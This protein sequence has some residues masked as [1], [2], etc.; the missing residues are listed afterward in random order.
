[1]KPASP[2]DLGLSLALLPPYSEEQIDL[3]QVDVT[4]LRCTLPTL[5]LD[6]F[7]N[8][9]GQPPSNVEL[10]SPGVIEQY[11]R[12]RFWLSFYRPD[13]HGHWSRE[14]SAQLAE[15]ATRF[16][17]RQ[18]GAEQPRISNGPLILAAVIGGFPIKRC[19]PNSPN[20]LLRM[21]IAEP[22]DD[23]ETHDPAWPQTLQLSRDIPRG[24]V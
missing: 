5:R 8:P 23:L 15:S 20:V 2:N 13:Y 11:L 12:A 7:E 9:A 3:A 21:R 24:R 18:F 4:A 6:G 1:V 22:R 14:H 17:E 10:E 19:G 16:F